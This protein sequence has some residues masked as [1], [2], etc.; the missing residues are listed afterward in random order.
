M[1]AGTSRIRNEI[2]G[3]AL[4]LVVIGLGFVVDVTTGRDLSLSLIYLSGVALMTWMGS[5]R[6]GIVGALLGATAVLVDGLANSVNTGPAISN[7]VTAFALLV[8]TTAVVDHYHARLV[9]E[10][11]RARFDPLTG[12]A[13]RRACEE[14]GAV[15]LARLQRHGG[16]LSIAYLDFDGLKEIND[17]YGH[18]A[19]DAALVDLAASAQSVL[20]PTDLLSRVGGDEFVLLLPDTDYD[21]AAAVTRRIQRKLAEP[22]GGP[23]ASVTV[24]LVTWRSAPQ[25]IEQMFVEADAL[26]YSAKRKRTSGDH[27]ESLVIG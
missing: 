1:V 11:G 12:L 14:R 9:R 23:P 4:G 21:D 17:V 3:I 15:E 2:V 10:A 5:F 25:S 19:G 13:N 16:S 24:G 26:M 18:A 7:A 8:A 22:N 27:F 6:V 20:R